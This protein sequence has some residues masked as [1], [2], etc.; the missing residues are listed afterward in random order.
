MCSVGH[1][2]FPF[3]K[4]VPK[5]FDLEDAI[6]LSDLALYY[7]KQNDRNLSIGIVPTEKAVSRDQKEELLKSLEF[8]IENKLWELMIVK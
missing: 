5:L 8:G 3:L 4:T 2:I 7:A 6:A 1:V